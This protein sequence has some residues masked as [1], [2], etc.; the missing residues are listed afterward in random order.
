MPV[1]LL[2]T[3]AAFKVMGFTINTLT[4]FAMV[5]AIGLAVDDAIVVIE[6]VERHIRYDK[7]KPLEATEKAMHDVSGPIIAIAF[8][9][10]SV[11][12]PVAFFSGT[13]GIL[14]KQFALTIVISMVLSAFVALSLTPTLCAALL[15]ADEENLLNRNLSC[16]VGLTILTMALNRVY[17]SMKRSCARSLLRKSTLYQGS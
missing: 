10:A 5:L 12:L 7:M 3:F 13:T 8:V 15:R 14:Y 4:L 16:S 17:G 9:L 11:F 1:S 6:A 2:G